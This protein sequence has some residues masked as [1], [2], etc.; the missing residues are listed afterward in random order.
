MLLPQVVV[1]GGGDNAG[2]FTS[3]RVFLKEAHGNYEG[4]FCMI[5]Q[6]SL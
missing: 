4:D 6:S 1:V 5:F 2:T 3:E